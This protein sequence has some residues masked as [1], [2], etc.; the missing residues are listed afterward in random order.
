MSD[1]KPKKWTVKRVSYARLEETLNE[2]AEI[3]S[4]VEYWHVGGNNDLCQV[5]A[6]KPFDNDEDDDDEGDDDE[7]PSDIFNGSMPKMSKAKAVLDVAWTG[8]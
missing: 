4:E 3:Y 1:D 6:H 8:F 7:F 5:T 2:L